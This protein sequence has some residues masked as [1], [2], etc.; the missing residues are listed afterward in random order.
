MTGTDSNSSLIDF[1]R[2]SNRWCNFVRNDVEP[3]LPFEDGQFQYVF[4][5]SVFSHFAEA[6]HLRW[7]EELRRIIKPGGAAAISVRGRNFIKS[8]REMRKSAPDVKSLRML[9]DTDRELARYDAG[10]FCFSPYRP[11]VDPWW[12]EACIPRAYVE[13]E[14]SRLFEVAE[15]VEGSSPVNLEELRRAPHP[16][17]EQNFVLLRA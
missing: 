7:L 12:G 3:P 1:C 16:T 14:W 5:Y 9:M 11:R 13:R 17:S 4:V 8:L 15:F 6:M 10:E 2:V